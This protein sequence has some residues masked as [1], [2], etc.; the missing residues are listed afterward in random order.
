MLTASSKA[1]VASFI[2]ENWVSENGRLSNQCGINVKKQEI[3]LPLCSPSP[4]YISTQVSYNPHIVVMQSLGKI[5]LLLPEYSGMSG[6]RHAW[7]LAFLARG[8]ELPFVKISRTSAAFVM[9]CRFFELM[10]SPT[11]ETKD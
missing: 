8:R 4:I 9:F 11:D 6:L 1:E 5:A 3:R 10:P 7:A 2:M